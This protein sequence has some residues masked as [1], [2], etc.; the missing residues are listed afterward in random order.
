MAI[1]L[2]NPERIAWGCYGFGTIGGDWP[3]W[4]ICQSRQKAKKMRAAAGGEDAGAALFRGEV[5]LSN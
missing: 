5:E 4:G 2:R 1:P 3:P